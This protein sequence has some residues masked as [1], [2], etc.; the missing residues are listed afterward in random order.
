MV[1]LNEYCRERTVPHLDKVATDH[2]DYI[3]YKGCTEY[4]EKCEQQVHDYSLLIIRGFG[5]L[6]CDFSLLNCDFSQFICEFSLKH[7]DDLKGPLNYK[8]SNHFD[9]APPGTSRVAAQTN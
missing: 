9:R 4:N 2:I 7:L 3:D 6:I 8:A 1:Q 5:Q